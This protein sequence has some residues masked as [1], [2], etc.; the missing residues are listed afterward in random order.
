MIIELRKY[1]Y[2]CDESQF[3]FKLFI[4]WMIEEKEIWNAVIRFCIRVISDKITKENEFEDHSFLRN[5]NGD[6]DDER[7]ERVID[8]LMSASLL[9]NCIGVYIF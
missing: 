5:R 7:A 8:S 4:P 2:N 3:S 1:N 6:D 9:A